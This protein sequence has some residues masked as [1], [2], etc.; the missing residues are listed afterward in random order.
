MTDIEKNK[1]TLNLIT[2]GSIL[3]SSIG[4]GFIISQKLSTINESITSVRT[5][6]HEAI[7]SV[8]NKQTYRGYQSDL[9][10]Q[11]IDQEQIIINEK[12]DRL[13]KR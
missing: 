4:L 12:L 1:V 13:M 5:E 10:F 7:D 2:A 9:K 3:I 11:K 6:M 8:K